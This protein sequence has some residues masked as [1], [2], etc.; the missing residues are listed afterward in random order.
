MLRLEPAKVLM[1][2]SPGENFE[3]ALDYTV[4]EAERRGCGIHLALAVRPV[5]VGPP[6]VTDL[7][8]VDGEWRKYG[9]DF[10]VEV[11]RRV[12]RAIGPTVPVSSEITHGSVV[13]ALVEVSQNAAIV[14][15]QHHRMD[16]ARHVRTLSVTNG[17]A[18]RAHAPVVAVPDSW[19]E[20]GQRSDVIVV[21]VEDAVSS[22]R[23]ARWAFE[24]AQRLG[25]SVRLVRAWFFSAA[26]D[27]DMFEGQAGLVHT[28]YVREGVRREFADLMESFPDV[29]CEVVAVHGP[30]ADALVAQSRSH[31]VRRIVVGRHEPT[32]PLGSHLGPVTR[33]VLNHS[34]C[35]V[36]VVD[37]RGT[38][39]TTATSRRTPASASLPGADVRAV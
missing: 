22:A 21:G 37:P 17:V 6:E 1:C 10:L 2:V 11:E 32:L 30:A 36:V 38:P 8:L 25:G 14:V 7:R 28:A 29:P 35:P 9:T 34:S 13:P 16:R 4:A 27:G 3:G 5:W 19:R 24:E 39:A 31:D 26:F 20:V 23:V 15:M 33:A 12:S 18:A